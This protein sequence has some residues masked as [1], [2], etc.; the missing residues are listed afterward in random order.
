M[1]L[2]TALGVSGVFCQNLKFPGSDESFDDELFFGDEFGQFF[3]FYSNQK[4]GL[5]VAGNVE[6]TELRTESSHD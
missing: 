3:G 4:M 6:L 2:D 1:R 5:C